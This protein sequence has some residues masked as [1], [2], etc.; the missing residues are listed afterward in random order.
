MWFQKK[1]ILFLIFI[2]ISAVTVAQEIPAKTDTTHLYEN[3]ATYSK[4]SRFASFIYHLIFRS[5]PTETPGNRKRRFKKVVLFPYSAFEGKIIRKIVITTLDPFGYS[6][7]DTSVSTQNIFVNA[8]NKM[9]I[10]TQRITIRDL[11]LFHK[12]ERFNSFL[13]KESERLIRSQK[14]VHEV[15]FNVFSSAAKSDSV[16]IYIRELDIWTIIPDG[17]ISTSGI[18]IGLTENNFVGTGHQF[19]NNYA[20]N[21]ST[22]INS[23]ITNYYIP[24]IRNTYINSTLHYG[25]DG[26]KNYNKSFAVDRP[27]YSA[28]A[29]WAAGISIASQFKKDSMQDL[30]SVFVPIRLRFNTQDYW[31]GFAQQLFKGTTELDRATNFILAMRYLQVR[32]FEKPAEI[33]DPLQNYSNENFYLSEVGISTRRYIQDKYIFNYG[34]IE[35][36][37]VGKVYSLTTGYQVKNNIGRMYLGMKFSTGN[38]NEF[39]YLSSSFEYGTFFH[40]AAAEQGVIR[41][42]ANYFTPLIEIGRWKFRQFVKP[43]MT[44]GINRFYYDTLTLKNYGLN[45]FNSSGLSGT[46]RLLL[47]LQTQSYSP[48]NFIGFRFGPFFILSLGMLGDAANGFSNSKV[49]SQIGLGVLIKNENLVFNTFQFSISFYPQIPGLGNDVFKTNSFKTNDIGFSDFTIE[50]PTPAVFQ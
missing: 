8:G 26:Y 13:V 39:G 38:Y 1:I 4:Q 45:G 41:A 43:Q 12:Y 7:T 40:A 27:F 18:K 44:I 16:D 48:W 22:G 32:Y 37:P 23:F 49:Y 42:E 10:K 28:L 21:F 34:V 3:I 33:Y 31:A 17:S 50:K 19:Q 24:N 9:H 5:V 25:T 6:V 15:A 30:N 47:T 14:F 2:I 29:K 20:K 11:L 35:D 46:S 36:V